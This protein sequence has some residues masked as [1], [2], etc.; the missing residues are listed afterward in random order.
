MEIELPVRSA[1]RHIGLP[2]AFLN[3]GALPTLHE[4]YGLSAQAITGEIKE[5]L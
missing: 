3:A 4:S 2:D 5:W 1:F